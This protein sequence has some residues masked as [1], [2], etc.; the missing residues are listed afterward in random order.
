MGPAITPANSLHHITS[1]LPAL[2][3]TSFLS[4]RTLEL[5]TESML[6]LFCL[7]GLKY[8]GAS[9]FPI[10]SMFFYIL[11]NNAYVDLVPTYAIG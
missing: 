3:P 8:L 2:L 11:D 9:L 10:Y 7:F 4:L 5:G 6:K 1:H